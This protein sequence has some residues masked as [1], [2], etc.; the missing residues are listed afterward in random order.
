MW[1]A[2]LAIRHILYKKNVTHIKQLLD[3]V[4]AAPLWLPAE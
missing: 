3:L 1:S 4:F 2:M